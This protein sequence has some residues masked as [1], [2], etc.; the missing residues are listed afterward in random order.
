MCLIHLFL[1]GPPEI[2]A[3]HLKIEKFYSPKFFIIYP[4][5]MGNVHNV[6]QG[7]KNRRAY[8]HY[9]LS[10]APKN[11]FLGLAQSACFRQYSSPCVEGSLSLF[12]RGKAAAADNY[13][14]CFNVKNKLY[15][16]IYMY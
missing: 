14:N 8:L 16:Y 13:D 5:A 15:I 3:S 1:T 9:A 7:Y 6:S 11:I 12:P 2:S 10:F 4:D